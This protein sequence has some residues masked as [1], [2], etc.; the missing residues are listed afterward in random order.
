MNEKS[1]LIGRLTRTNRIFSQNL[2]GSDKLIGVSQDGSREWTTI[3]AAICGDGTAQQG[4]SSV[5]TMS[6]VLSHY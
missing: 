5:G 4:R 6:R 1:F 2:R 3:V